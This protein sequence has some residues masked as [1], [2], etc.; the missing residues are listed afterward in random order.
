MAVEDDGRK[1]GALVAKSVTAGALALATPGAGLLAALAAISPDVVAH[2][3][4]KILRPRV[5]KFFS[6]FARDEVPF[7]D[8]EARLHAELLTDPHLAQTVWSA[9]RAV[10]EVLDD[11]VVPTLGA[12][13]AEYREQKKPADSFFRGVAGILAGLSADEF[14]AL[15]ELVAACDRFEKDGD[16][17]IVHANPDT[18]KLMIPDGNSGWDEVG[19][20]S[21]HTEALFR[22]LKAQ[23]LAAEAAAGSFGEQS[24]PDYLCIRRDTVLRLMRILTD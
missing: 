20:V 21:P 12:L 22:L 14:V 13:A 17:R 5:D 23:G 9:V 8:I 15:K 10:L 16:P 2:L 7:E 18:G 3:Y 1:R 11:S 6:R 24:G 4:E 19:Q